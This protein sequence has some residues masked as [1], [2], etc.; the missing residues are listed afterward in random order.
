[1]SKLTYQIKKF[2]ASHHKISVDR[3][4]IIIII[5]LY[6]EKSYTYKL[7]T[8]LHNITYYYFLF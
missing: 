4:V 5:K 7:T 3:I 2:A 8:K 1:M 6:N